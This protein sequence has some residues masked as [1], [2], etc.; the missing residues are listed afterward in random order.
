MTQYFLGLDAGGTKTYALVGNEKGEILGFG[1]AGTGNYEVRGVDA[2]RDSI[3]SAVRQALKTAGIRS[4]ELSHIGMGVA[5]ADLPEDYEMLEREIFT[6]LFG[7]LPRV[8]RNDSMA[9]L[10][11]GVRGPYGIVIACGT[12]CVCA[13]INA[14]GEETRVGGINEDFGDVVS[15]TS[16]GYRALQAV[17]QARD[18]ILPLTLLTELLV[19]RAGCQDIEELFIRMYRE[20]ISQEDLEPI[21]PLVFQAA[22]QGDVAA[23]DILEWAGRFLGQTV[24]AAARRLHMQDQAFDVVMAGSVFKGDSPILKDALA[25]TLHRDCPDAR[26]VMPTYEPVVGALLLGLDQL[27]TMDAAF[28]DRLNQSLMQASTRYNVALFME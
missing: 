26:L 20:E 15:G 17:F 18:N 9:G 5:G 24:A 23:C 10:R 11:G 21:A 2:A 14:Q 7:E 16:I 8:F 12:G 4:E 3:E 6:P 22:R 13:G 28:Y 25:L 1:R 27:G 19:E